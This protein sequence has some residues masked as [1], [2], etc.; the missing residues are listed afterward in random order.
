MLEV[1]IARPVST[2]LA[3]KA[4]Y[5]VPEARLHLYRQVRGC[6]M[7]RQATGR[8]YILQQTYGTSFEGPPFPERKRNFDNMHR[9]MPEQGLRTWC[10]RLGR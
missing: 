6:L 5:L 3:S 2:P 8:F 7:Q 9:S 10:Q 4:T 1:P